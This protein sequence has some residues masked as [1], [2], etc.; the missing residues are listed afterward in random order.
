MEEEN[1][2]EKHQKRKKV[3]AR[4]W[5]DLRMARTEVGPYPWSCAIIPNTL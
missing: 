3:S 2:Y 4:A 5:A 1:G